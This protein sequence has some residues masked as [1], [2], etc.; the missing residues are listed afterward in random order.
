MKIL[1][2]PTA[3]TM[4]A[5][6]RERCEEMREIKEGDPFDYGDEASI[7]CC[8]K[9]RVPDPSPGQRWGKFIGK[10]K[11]GYTII[12]IDFDYRILGGQQ[13]D[14]IAEMQQTWIVD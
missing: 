5:I 9:T 11:D 13:F 4:Y 12:L 7:G 3:S 8:V 6:Q 2:I 14:S 1:D 10:L